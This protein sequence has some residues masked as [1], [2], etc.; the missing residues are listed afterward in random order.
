MVRAYLAQAGLPDYKGD[1]PYHPVY[2]PLSRQ[3]ADHYHQ[4]P[5]APGSRPVRQ[6][7]D[8]MRRDVLDQYRFLQDAGVDL[9][10]WTREGQP[11]ANSREMRDDA[12]G[13]H[14]HYYLGGDFPEDSLIHTP[15]PVRSHGHT[16]TYNDL[17]RAVHD[18][19]GHALYGNQFGPR[20]EEH[21]WRTH[22]HMFSPEAVPAMSFETRGQNSWVNFGPHLRRPD[23]SIPGPG[24]MG[25]IAPPDRPFGRQKN[26]ILPPGLLRDTP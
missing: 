13:G 24:E 20:G 22:K 19:F 21:A 17:F 4:A 2:E 3:I 12:L 25:Y 14:L 1:T 10:P 15:S 16:H 26:N 7:Y 9:E 18:F 5:H 11:Y 6:A 23:G 8:A